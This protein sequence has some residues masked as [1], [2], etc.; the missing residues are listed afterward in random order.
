MYSFQSNTNRSVIS[1]SNIINRNAGPVDSKDTIT[2]RSMKSIKKN[3]V[4]LESSDVIRLRALQ[5]ISKGNQ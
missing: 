5:Q 4:N 2:N 3:G 1:M